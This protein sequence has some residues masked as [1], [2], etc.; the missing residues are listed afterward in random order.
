[1]R[2]RETNSESFSDR[3][4]DRFV[5]GVTRSSSPA[6]RSAP[7]P[8][9]RAIV[10]PRTPPGTAPVPA[11][12]REFAIRARF[13]ARSPGCS[14]S[15]W[16]MRAHSRSP[17]IR[18]LRR[19]ASDAQVPASPVLAAPSPR[20]PVL[21]APSPRKC[22]RVCHPRAISRPITSLFRAHPT[23][24]R[25]FASPR[26]PSNCHTPPPITCPAASPLPSPN[27]APRT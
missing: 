14:V 3:P 24:A 15:T 26:S 21:A 13:R 11:N 16:R 10:W 9:T 12:A 6:P 22:A 5:T 8:R 2:F 1:M 18:P 27:P 17:P 7:G 25:A 4:A 20:L 23:N 19:S